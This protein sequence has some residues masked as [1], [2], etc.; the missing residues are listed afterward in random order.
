MEGVGGLM[1]M[2]GTRGWSECE[3]VESDMSVA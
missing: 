2:A 3:R 1:V